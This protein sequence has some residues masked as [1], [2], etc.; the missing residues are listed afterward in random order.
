MAD[1]LVGVR[2]H[3]WLAEEGVRGEGEG[4]GR[5]TE[6]EADEVEMHFGSVFVWFDSIVGMGCGSELRVIVGF[7]PT[8]CSQ[9]SQAA[10]DSRR[11]MC[12]SVVQRSMYSQ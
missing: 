11:C 10:V 3:G 12:T 7:I 5:E 2:C 9:D 4:Q 1:G 8:D 6:S